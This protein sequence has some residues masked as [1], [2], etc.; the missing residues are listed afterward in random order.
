MEFSLFGFKIN[1]VNALI[2]LVLG[3]L[4]ATLSVC[5][6]TKV[7]VKEA[8][9][10]LTGASELEGVNNSEVKDSLATKAAGY[11]G[12][13]GYETLLQRRD[14]VKGTAVPLEDTM[15]FFRD[16]DFSHECC[17]STF[18]SNK[19]CACTS[20]EQMN[21]LNERGGNRSGGSIF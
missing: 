14:T 12:N 8:M 16:N 20:V 1:V 6:C 19:G 13:M 15:V 10:T 7:S 9:S 3:F 2:F 5:S 11:A 18:S 17:P 21:Y 4:I